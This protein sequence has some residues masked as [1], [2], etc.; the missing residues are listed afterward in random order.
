MTLVAFHPIIR[1]WFE[2]RFGAPIGAQA[3]GWPAIASGRHTLTA[4]AGTSPPRR[5]AQRIVILA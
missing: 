5:G 3:Q 1:T 2:R 4:Q